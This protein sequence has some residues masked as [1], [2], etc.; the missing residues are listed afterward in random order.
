[1]NCL[2]VF[3]FEC[4]FHEFFKL[5][6]IKEFSSSGLQGGW[7]Q[8]PKILVQFENIFTVLKWIFWWLHLWFCIKWPIFIRSIW[9]RSRRWRRSWSILINAVISC[10]KGPP[11]T[12]CEAFLLETQRTIILG[13]LNYFIQIDNFLLK[14]SI[15]S[16]PLLKFEIKG[17]YPPT[18]CKP[19][20]VYWKFNC[21]EIRI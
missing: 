12:K 15:K 19:V 3:F 17:I 7:I 2:F 16:N 10:V 6:I 5:I 4:I 21:L 14:L 18:L 1:M 8:G 13:F 20:I 9:L 11:S